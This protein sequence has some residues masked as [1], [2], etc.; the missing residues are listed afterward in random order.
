MK[1]TGGGSP[2][3]IYRSRC[4]ALIRACLFSQLP[5]GSIIIPNCPLLLKL[6][7][8]AQRY[9]RPAGRCCTGDRRSRRRRDASCRV[10][11]RGHSP[12]RHGPRGRYAQDPRQDAVCG[13]PILLLH[14][15]LTACSLV[16]PN[17]P[18]IIV[19]TQPQCHSHGYLT[20]HAVPW[21]VQD[22]NHARLYS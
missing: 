14:F 2:L 7:R 19:R 13:S 1:E 16:G 18:G 12:E 22:W 4:F 9:L 6:T 15:A 21:P 11:H 17:C 20:E 5:P 3:T 8:P 10:H